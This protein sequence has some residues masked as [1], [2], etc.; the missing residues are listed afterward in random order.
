MSKFYIKK[1]IRDDGETLEID[2]T[3]LYLYEENA[4][5]ARPDPE[6]TSISYTEHDGGEMLH[7]K[8]P[9]HDQTIQGLII[10]RA[11]NYWTLALRLTSFWR[12]NHTYRIIYERKN[13]TLL[14][15]SDAWISAG[16]QVPPRA[17]E[18]YTVWTV[19]LTIGDPNWREYA[20]DAEGNE[21][22]AS[23][24]TLPLVYAAQ[25]GEIWDEVGLKS[26]EIGEAWT[27]G[28]GGIQTVFCNS[29]VAIY[30]IW[31]VEG[32]CANPTLQN[33]TTNT[34]VTFNGTVA[35]GQKLTVNLE[36]GV[37]YLDRALATRYVTGLMNLAPGAN[38]VDFRSDGGS[39]TD[40][41]IQ[42]N[43]VIG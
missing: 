11:T 29:S 34:E 6:T 4:L 3:N 32:E 26:D 33:N 35:S 39:A 30:P 40:C 42:W 9:P 31:I 41:I 24:V 22:Y 38:L 17:D 43:N 25:G 14:S 15:V 18:D 2:R 20:E 23:N 19:G 28:T 27:Q 36:T 13:G 8:N 10:P 5:L 21:T 12:I 16:L 1:F 7:Q 37:A